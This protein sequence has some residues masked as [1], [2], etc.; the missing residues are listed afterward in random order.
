MNE[1]FPKED[2]SLI[3]LPTVLLFHCSGVLDFERW[4]CILY[5]KQPLYLGHYP[6][7]HRRNLRNFVYFL[8]KLDSIGLSN[9]FVNYVAKM[10]HMI[11]FFSKRSWLHYTTTV[12][13]LGCL[14]VLD[15]KG[16]AYIFLMTKTSTPWILAVAPSKK[17]EK[18][19]KNNASSR[20]FFWK[21]RF[22]KKD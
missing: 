22:I 4:T 5:V 8:E 1:I 15:F 17:F 3:K 14:W 21:T 19:K 2:G 13:L 6:W 7:H 20:F 16:W 9:L 18:F 10:K 11:R 12:F